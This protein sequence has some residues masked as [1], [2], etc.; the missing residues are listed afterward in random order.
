M[1]P[2]GSGEWSRL[3]SIAGCHKQFDRSVC[4]NVH[5]YRLKPFT[6]LEHWINTEFCRSMKMIENGEEEQQ[7]VEKIWEFFTF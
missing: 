4:I 6:L 7:Q 1:V 5:H 2:I 3:E